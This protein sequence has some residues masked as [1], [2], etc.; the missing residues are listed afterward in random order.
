MLE[1]V[2]IH[3]PEQLD[4][5]ARSRGYRRAIAASGHPSLNFLW[6]I[7]AGLLDLDWRDLPLERTLQLRDQLAAGGRGAGGTDMTDPESE[8]PETPDEGAYQHLPARVRPED[9]TAAQESQPVPDPTMGRDPDHDF[10]LRH[11][12]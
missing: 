7:E 4:E 2:G 6:S 9:T 1:A 11:S 8:V 10:L 12:G 5:W 3:T